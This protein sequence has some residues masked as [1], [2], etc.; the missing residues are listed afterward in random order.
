MLGDPVNYQKLQFSSCS[1]CSC[2]TAGASALFFT[3]LAS[4]RRPIISVILL[5]T[6][7]HESLR[8]GVENNPRVWEHGTFMFLL[9]A[10]VGIK[11]LTTPFRQILGSCPQNYGLFSIPALRFSWVGVIN[12]YSCSYEHHLSG[13]PCCNISLL[14]FLP[15]ST[16][17]V[18]PFPS[19]HGTCWI[20][21]KVSPEYM[22]ISA[23]CT[24]KSDFL[25][26]VF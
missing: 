8:A 11:T 15:S 1:T 22:L 13:S 12:K 5:W 19:L 9:K 6:S 25:K 14:Y 18:S 7:T 10:T 23:R 24:L 20:V 2:N 17:L 4:K 26:L 16:P 21:A 3:L